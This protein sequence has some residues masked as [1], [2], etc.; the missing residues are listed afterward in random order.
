MDDKQL[1]ELA[2]MVV[3][4]E[5]L[6][7]SAS[8]HEA[9]IA[10]IGPSG[11]VHGPIR[12]LMVGAATGLAAAACLVIGLLIMRPAPRIP[13]VPETRLADKGPSGHGG[14]Q[15]PAPTIVKTSATEKC[16]VMSMF[17]D[18][19]GRCSCLQVSEPQWEGGRPLADVSRS[20]LHRVALAQPCDTEAQ[21]VIIVAVAGRADTLPGHEQAEAIAQ[22]ISTAAASVGRHTDVTSFARAAMPGLSDGATVVAETVSMR[23][24][25]RVKDLLRDATSGWK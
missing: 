19:N 10:R 18:T 13:A 24:P 21:Q 20:E 17:R 16:V 14:D 4:I 11:L 15:A 8:G 7:Q 3:E 9:P 22:Q 1:Q 5:A 2:R 25:S 6:E 23:Q 12:R